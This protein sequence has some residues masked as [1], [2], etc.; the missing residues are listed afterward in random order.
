MN[1]DTP[2]PFDIIAWLVAV[3]TALFGASAHCVRLLAAMRGRTRRGFTR[4]ARRWTQRGYA[5]AYIGE[6]DATVAKR[7]ARIQWMAADPWKALRHLARRARG[8]LRA[9]LCRASAPLSF[10]PPVQ[11]CA[12]CSA[13]LQTGPAE[14]MEPP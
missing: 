4:L 6:D 13:G 10:V 5:I 9:W 11:A 1:P 8:L 7:I 12:P 14:A 3:L 2:S